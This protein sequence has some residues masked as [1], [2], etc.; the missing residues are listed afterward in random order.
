MTSVR[1]PGTLT[2]DSGKSALS[3]PAVLLKNFEEYCKT[4]LRYLKNDPLIPTFLLRKVK[5][6]WWNEKFQEHLGRSP[7]YRPAK[8]L[9]AC[10]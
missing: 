8:Q 6:T 1:P 5:D 10:N 7:P 3:E 9:I 2:K 4:N